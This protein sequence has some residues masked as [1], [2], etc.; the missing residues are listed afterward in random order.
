MTLTERRI[1]QAKYRIKKT[2]ITD[3]FHLWTPEE[4]RK[5]SRLRKSIFNKAL[6]QMIAEKALNKHRDRRRGLTF[7]I[8]STECREELVKNPTVP[9]PRVPA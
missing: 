1:E 9:K 6:G 3:L 5:A 8:V 4:L 2:V 7:I